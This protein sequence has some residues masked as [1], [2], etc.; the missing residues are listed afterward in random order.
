MYEYMRE[1]NYPLAIDSKIGFAGKE[2]KLGE[3]QNISAMDGNKIV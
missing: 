1:N 2:K 3:D